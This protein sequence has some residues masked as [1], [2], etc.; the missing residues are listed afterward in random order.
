VRA[1]TAIPALR[2]GLAIRLGLGAEDS[3]EEIAA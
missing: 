3:F 1:K 2:Q